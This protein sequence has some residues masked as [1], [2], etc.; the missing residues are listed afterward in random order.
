M[1]YVCKTD[2]GAGQRCG[3]AASASLIIVEPGGTASRPVSGTVDLCMG[4]LVA[5]M[6]H[7]GV[8]PQDMGA[9]IETLGRR[10]I[11]LLGE[12]NT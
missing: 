8:D 4:H 3:R 9:A 2:D 1:T 12:D 6:M 7:N 10:M 5:L 11:H